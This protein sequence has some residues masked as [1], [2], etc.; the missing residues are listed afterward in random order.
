[1][2]ATNKFENSSRK[3]ERLTYLYILVKLNAK[4]LHFTRII[5]DNYFVYI[6]RTSSE[7]NFV[8]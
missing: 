5:H 1:M 8:N 6:L 2:G 3:D 7:F 4:F